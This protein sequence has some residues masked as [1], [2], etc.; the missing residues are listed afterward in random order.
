MTGLYQVLRRYYSL[1]RFLEQ[2]AIARA[3]PVE[4]LRDEEVLDG[5]MP[6]VVLG[7]TRRRDLW[8]L[9]YEQTYL[10][11]DV[12]D[13]SQV[14]DLVTFRNVL[15]LAALRSAQILNQSELG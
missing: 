7:E 2:V 10:E 14:A 8:F 6:S 12:R 4:P 5:G 11:R 15:R 9:G 1:V 13:L 3:K